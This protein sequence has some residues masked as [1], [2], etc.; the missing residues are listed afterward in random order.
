[1]CTFQP[2]DAGQQEETEAT[3]TALSSVLSVAS[4]LRPDTLLTPASVEQD[5]GSPEGRAGFQFGAPPALPKSG[6]G[7][8]GGGS[9]VTPP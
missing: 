8:P 7:K 2:Q 5:S 9:I 3:E 1:M 4:C 6:L